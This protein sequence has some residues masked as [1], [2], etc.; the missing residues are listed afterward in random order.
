[1][2]DINQEG[3]KKEKKIYKSVSEL[4]K[5]MLYFSHS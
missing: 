1:M 5:I 4:L 3:L 2:I